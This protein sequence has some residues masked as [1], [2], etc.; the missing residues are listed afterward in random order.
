[1][2]IVAAAVLSLALL[3]SREKPR[4]GPR[5]GGAVL[6]PLVVIILLIIVPVL[7]SQIANQICR[8]TPYA[9]RGLAY[10]RLCVS[11]PPPPPLPPPP[12]PQE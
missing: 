7:T 6:I 9:L 4:L 12:L 8:T 5:K 3:E 11:P 10:S 2:L 1:M